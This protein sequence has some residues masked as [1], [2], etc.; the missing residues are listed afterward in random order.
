MGSNSP[1]IYRLSSHHKTLKNLQFFPA[2]HRLEKFRFL[3]LKYVAA[4]R[5]I[6]FFEL[7]KV[8]FQGV[9]SP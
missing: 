7:L 3:I 2:N 5:R 4:A 9:P 8:V 6:F 1:L